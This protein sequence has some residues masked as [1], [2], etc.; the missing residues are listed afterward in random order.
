MK[1]ED[2]TTREKIIDNQRQLAE[3]RF[4]F[5]QLD[6]ISALAGLDENGQILPPPEDFTIN[7]NPMWFWST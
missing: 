1:Y 6:R 5:E 7:R 4:K 3:F 2:M